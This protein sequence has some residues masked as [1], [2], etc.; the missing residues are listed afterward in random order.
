MADSLGLW[1]QRFLAHLR[2]TRGVSPHT[3]R[4]YSGDLGEL[5]KFAGAGLPVASLDR[6]RVRAW[7]AELQGRG[8]ARASV[9]RKASS[10]RSLTAYLLDQEGLASDPFLNV[11]LPKREKRLPRFLTESEMER[12]L[13]A[14]SPVGG[15]P[16]RRRDRAM[17]ELFY[18]AGLRRSELRGLNVGDVDFLGGV[19]RVMGKGSRERVVPVGDAALQALRGYLDSRAGP[20][21]GRDSRLGGQQPLFANADG[22]RLSDAGVAF[23]VRRWTRAAAALKSVSPHVFRHSF[24]THLVSRGCDI[25]TVQEMLGHRSLANTQI[26]THLSLERLREVYEKSHPGAKRPESPFGHPRGGA[27]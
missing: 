11:R 5:L 4:A 6:S 25:R 23:V 2:G 14:R 13:A 27:G 21:G 22:A 20:G 24:A 16:L 8:L 1:V 18:S 19:V 12:L 17:I 3:L 7:L 10:L 26:Y 9:L 15:E